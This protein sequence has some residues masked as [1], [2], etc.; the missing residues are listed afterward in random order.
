M[1]VTVAI[2]FEGKKIRIGGSGPMSFNTSQM[3][4]LGS[5]ANKTVI[6]R[7]RSGIGSDDAAFPPLST[8]TSAIRV[9]GKFLRQHAGYAAWKSAHGLAPIRDMWGTGAQN[10]HML[11]NSTVRYADDTT[12][13]I[14]F[15][16]RMARIKALSNERRTPFYSFSEMDQKKIIDF[17]AKLWSSNVKKVIAAFTGRRAA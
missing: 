8:K 3:L 5:F 12:V 16:A 2:K 11:D 13:K 14:A 1:A 17:A 15:T 7:T 10:G 9:N 6:A 4:Q